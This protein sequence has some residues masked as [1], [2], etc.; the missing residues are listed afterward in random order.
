M[1]WLG[2]TCCILWADHPSTMAIIGV[3]VVVAGLASARWLKRYAPGLAF[4]AVALVIYPT[5]LW[6]VSGPAESAAAAAWSCKLFLVAAA[7]VVFFALTSP[8]QLIVALRALRAPRGPTLALAVGL[9]TIPTALDEVERVIRAQRARGLGG[10]RHLLD[11]RRTLTLLSALLV[12]C[13][14]GMLTEALRVVVALHLRGLSDTRSWQSPVV[15]WHVLDLVLGAYSL[16]I[17]PLAFLR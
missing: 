8:A 14:S 6:A 2:A 12:P 1:L 13:L 7:S 15:Q 17:M 11:P 4:L 9:Q 3:P 5:F 10:R 16:S